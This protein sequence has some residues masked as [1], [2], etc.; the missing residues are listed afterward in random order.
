MSLDNI[1]LLDADRFVRMEHHAMLKTLREQAPL[2]WH[3]DPQ[4]GG[5]WNVVRHADVTTVNRD[6]ELY[7]SE[8]GGISIPNPREVTDDGGFVDQRGLNML[9]TDPP[10][11]TRYRRLVSKG[12]TPRMMR[13]LEQF[14]AHRATIIVDNVIQKGEA[15]FVEDIAAELPLQAI[16]EIIGVPQ[17]DRHLLFKWS[18]DLIGIDDPE[19]EGDPGVAA[20]EL[21]S[22]AHQLAADRGIDPQDD[23]M[24]KLV[25]AEIDGDRLTELEI[26]V[27]MLL[28]SVAG[29]E[30]TRNATAH[31][32]HAF[33]TNPD[34]FSLLK[35][36]VDKYID[37]AV[38][39]VIR[40]ASP[41]LHFRRTT[42]QPV[43]LLGQEI[44]EGS[45]VVM[46][47][48]SA[49][50]DEDVFSDPYSF[51][52]TR[53]PNDHIAFGAGGAHYCLGAN[54]ARAELRLIFQEIATRMPDMK[55]EGEP[56][57]LRSN[58]IGG[59]KHLPVSWTPGPRVD[60]PPYKR[61]TKLTDF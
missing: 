1:D 54:L 8:I 22:Y 12:F 13:L 43:E 11:H 21:Y 55:M 6:N 46:W 45:R 14:L 47:Y 30:T 16:A 27:F 35:S 37:T 32:M 51:D 23:I 31:G 53:S 38:D 50:R 10:K 9:Y 4:G 5:F 58:F 20:M 15:D 17:E 33:L 39:E 44:E 48:I 29:N 3:K 57:R 2:Y 28:L 18:I 60:P 40:W 19:Y 41:V 7:S 56:Q 49:N 34:Q 61:E 59:I 25:N 52:I 24:T 36:N 42:T 26:D